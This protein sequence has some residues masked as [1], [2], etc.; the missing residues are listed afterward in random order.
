ME[1]KMKGLQYNKENMIKM[2]SGEVQ[3]LYMVND[4]LEKKNGQ[5]EQDCKELKVEIQRMW[6]KLENPQ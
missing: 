6:K 3:E 2:R 1:E 4:E 5:L